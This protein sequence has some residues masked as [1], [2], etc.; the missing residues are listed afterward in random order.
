M[1]KYT[2]KLISDREPSALKKTLDDVIR[3]LLWGRE[4]WGND[5][6]GPLRR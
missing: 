5:P 3:G 1:V 6:L 4:G 2:V